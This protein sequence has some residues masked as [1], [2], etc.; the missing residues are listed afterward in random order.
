MYI[1]SHCWEAKTGPL[2]VN[3]A[4]NHRENSGNL[5][6]IRFATVAPIRRSPRITRVISSRRGVVFYAIV[7]LSTKRVDK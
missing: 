2:F 5:P 3:I 4:V 1:Q 6:K 7:Q